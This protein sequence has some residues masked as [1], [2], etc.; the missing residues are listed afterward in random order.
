ML[1]KPTKRVKGHPLQP[2]PLGI[3]FLLFQTSFKSWMGSISP[4]TRPSWWFQPI[5][6]IFLKLDHFPNF[7]GKNKKCLKPPPSLLW[8]TLL[9]W[10][11]FW[12]T[13]CHVFIMGSISHVLDFCLGSS[14]HFF[15]LHPKYRHRTTA[16]SGALLLIG[17][18]PSSAPVAN[19][20][21]APLGW[22]KKLHG[23]GLF[24]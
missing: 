11:F 7:R 19:L 4:C 17:I 24:T 22:D 15:C 14:P 23:T 21:E 9:K 16:N 12:E 5:W 10:M 3:G 18:F 8:K 2:C 6:N 13:Q 20:T 1:K